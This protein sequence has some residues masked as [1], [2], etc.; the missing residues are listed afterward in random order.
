LIPWAR[1]AKAHKDTDDV[2]QAAKLWQWLDEQ[3]KD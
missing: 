3:V 2:E 1:V